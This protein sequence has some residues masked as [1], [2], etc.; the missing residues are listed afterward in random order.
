MIE[1]LTSGISSTQT[2]PIP[3]YHNAPPDAPE[4]SFAEIAEQYW[5]KEERGSAL[6]FLRNLSADDLET[7]GE[8]HRFANTIP[9]LA[10]ITSEGANN[11]LRAKGETIDENHDGID[12]IGEA[13][14]FRFPNSNTPENVKAAWADATAD[15][16]ESNRLMTMAIFL[17]L[18]QIETDASGRLTRVINPGEPDYNNPM[19][20]PGYSY[21]R[22]VENKLRAL[23]DPSNP[24]NDY[25]FYRKT[26][27]FYQNLLESFATHGVR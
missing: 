2:I 10:G 19:E 27:E 22:T 7:I 26:K 20:Q 3:Q 1:T 15:L 5:S 6:D 16:D 13:R 23:D 12:Q 8:Q 21:A 18:P 11:L 4:R 25:E 24:P 9:N 17:P 14:T